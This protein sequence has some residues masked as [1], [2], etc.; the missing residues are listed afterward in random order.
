VSA[1]ATRKTTEVAVGV[2]LRGDGQV[3][4]ADRP[5][6]KAYAGYWEF[7][8][9]KIE[10]GESVT[11]ALAR[12]LHEELGI[13]IGLAQPWV[14]FEFDYPHAYVRLQFCRVN[15]WRGELVAREAQRLAFFDP[16]GALPEPLLPAAV[17]AL[18][19]LRLPPA[20]GTRL[21]CGD[22]D[23]LTVC[24]WSDRGSQQ[25]MPPL[26][27]SAEELLRLDER[28][29]SGWVG[30]EVGDR[31]GLLRAARMSFDFAVALP[32]TA[33]ALTDAPPLPLYLP[34]SDWDAWREGR[35]AG[36]AH[37]IWLDSD[38]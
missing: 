14:T 18:R 27:F 24:R 34:R 5:Q 20:A 2:L 6:G 32:G 10:P 33:A 12:E 35:I 11:A 3:L 30:A 17:P 15:S 37:G 25:A 26:L 22:A 23:A 38:R 16:A 21:G 29:D 13:D 7:P 4:L 9:G 19:W 28:P 1:A 36:A 31:D 8:G